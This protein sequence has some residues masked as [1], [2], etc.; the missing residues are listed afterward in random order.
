MS[1]QLSA[2]KHHC[3]TT[4]NYI[5]THNFQTEIQRRKIKKD[6][7]LRQVQYPKH[8]RIKLQNVITTDESLKF[9]VILIYKFLRI[10]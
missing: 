7:M 1:V 8:T 4:L 2:G 10:I 9:T 3:T 6:T 5:V